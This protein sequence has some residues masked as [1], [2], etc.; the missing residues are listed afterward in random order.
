MIIHVHKRFYRIG[1]SYLSFDAVRTIQTS[2]EKNSN[3]LSI[4]FSFG[5]HNL[6]LKDEAI[7]MLHKHALN[8]AT[9]RILDKELVISKYNESRLM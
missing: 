8:N 3:F 7:A 9:L 2:I 1:S 5:H 4:F 6:L